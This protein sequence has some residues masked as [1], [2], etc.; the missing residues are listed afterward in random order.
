LRSTKA[1]QVAEE[2]GIRRPG[3]IHHLERRRSAGLDL[4][5]QFSRDVAFYRCFYAYDFPYVN[6]RTDCGLIVAYSLL[7]Y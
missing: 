4:Y 2:P 3:R 6:Q 7:H 5:G 1:A